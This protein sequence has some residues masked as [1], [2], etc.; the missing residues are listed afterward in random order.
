VYSTIASCDIWYAALDG[1]DS[2]FVVGGPQSE[3]NP[4]PHPSAPY[5]LYDSNETGTR[6][7]FLTTYPVAGARWQVSTAGGDHA[8]WSRRGDRVY[9]Y[10]A[11]GLWE[12]EVGLS[13][14]V[15]LGQPRQLFAFDR[16]GIQSWGRTTV[17]PTADPNRFVALLAEREA[18]GGRSDA[19]L[20]E[21]WIAEFAARKK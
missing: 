5:L 9:Y 12:V 8:M 2:A 17:V 4:A 3:A 1:G 11:K 10:D 14:Q 20:V 15:R 6:N 19:L 13:P 18:S 7:V 16:T 21:N